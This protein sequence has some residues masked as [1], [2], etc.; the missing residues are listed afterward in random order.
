M[1]ADT[2]LEI[3]NLSVTYRQGRTAIPALRN[4]SLTLKQG[5][6][7]GIIG[8]SGSGKS[9]LAFAIMR[10]LG[11]N[12]HIE[13][14]SILFKGEDILRKSEQEMRALRGERIAMVYQQPQ[15]A[16]NPSIPIGDQVAEVFMTHTR[17]SARDAYRQ[18]VEMLERVR[19]TDPAGTAKLYPHQA[20]GGMQQRVVIAMALAM[21]PDLLILDEPT[22]ALDVTT[23]AA[24]LELLEELRRDFGT[25]LI[26]VAHDLA[27]ITR[28]CER[29]AVFYAGEMLE[30]ATLRDIFHAPH[31]P[32]TAGLL[33]CLP[34]RGVSDGV[35]GGMGHTRQPLTPIPGRLPRLTNLPPGCV[36]QPRCRYAH[37]NCTESHPDLVE[38][39]PGHQ[40]RC[41]YWPEVHVATGPSRNGHAA[42]GHA[43]V[44]PV[45]A[46]SGSA[47]E[48]LLRVQD[49][50]KSFGRG[51]DHNVRVLNS[52]NMSLGDGATIGL[53]GESGSGKTTLARCI[54]GLTA[55][56]RGRITFKARDLP[57]HVGNRGPDTLR[58][59]QMVFQNPDMSLNPRQTIRTILT[60]PIRLLNRMGRRE[61]DA[62]ARDLLRSVNLDE[63]YMDRYPAQLSGGEKQRVAIARAFATR[64]KLVLCDEPVS[65]L[66][67]SVQA[68]VL[69]LLQDLQARWGT[70]YLF[71][72]HDLEVVQYLAD[73]IVVMYRGNI[74]ET[75]TTDQVFSGPNHPYTELLL[76]SI[77]RPDPDAPRTRLALE[78][79]TRT[80]AS[81]GVGCPFKGRCHRHIG[82]ICDTE[83]PPLRTVAGG[84]LT[85]C[86]LPIEELPT[87]ATHAMDAEPQAVS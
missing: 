69:N 38:T 67:V 66:D 7:Y 44:A 6:A 36:F 55:A 30:E 50:I 63:G 74:V 85:L 60:R 35:G 8:E 81:D 10:Y 61:A 26:F 51:A 47:E 33:E 4:V 32:Y 16:L 56:D 34:A 24:V 25:S 43:A 11:A 46:G 20:S 57:L 2:L 53:V 42:N 70:A 9:T 84:H 1:N 86:H 87:A 40:A 64:T 78:S 59:L 5:E 82:P 41:F 19:M 73:R 80:E 17:A 83:F 58:D 65:G 79:E 29:I 27:V 68:T 28:I 52:V 75:G 21:H 22:T 23:Q 39:N 72:S 54:L 77:P 14:G 18:A 76:T 45:L 62:A 37:A 49:I 48:P 3:R 15:A 13:S 12:G 31:H 71:I